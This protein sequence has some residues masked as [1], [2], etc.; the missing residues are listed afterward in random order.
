MPRRTSILVALR[1]T[2]TMLVA[3]FITWVS[4]TGFAHETDEKEEYAKK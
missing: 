1:L 4:E 3:G 2:I